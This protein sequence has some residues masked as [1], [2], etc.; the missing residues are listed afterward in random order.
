MSLNKIAIIP[1]RGGSKRI[2]GK[3]IKSFE[4]RP[5]ISYSITAAIDSK[6]FDEVMVSTDDHEI[7]TIALQYGATVPFLRSH[8]ASDDFASTEDVILEVI[9]Q[10]HSSG[11]QFEVGCCIYPTAPFATVKLI[12]DGF[13]LLDSGSFDTVFPVVQFDY[14]IQRSLQFSD[15]GK[16]EMVWPQYL[17]S[18]SQDLPNRFHDTGMFYWFRTHQFLEDKKL[19]GENS[20]AIIIS[21][22]QCHDIDTT[23]DWEM[24]EI[25]YRRLKNLKK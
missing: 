6:L 10:Y 11:K 5:I 9:T 18:R 7:A 13:H 25:K 4:G 12:Q 16:I 21:E 22:L 17:D 19:F 15:K 14:P 20:G 3:N 1:A 24:A 2:P 23:D 8:K